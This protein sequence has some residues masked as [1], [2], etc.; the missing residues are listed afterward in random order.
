M[1]PSRRKHLLYCLGILGV[2]ESLIFAYSVFYRGEGGINGIGL[3]LGFVTL[4]WF[5]VM[6]TL[7]VTRKLR[8]KIAGG[9]TFLIL[10]CAEIIISLPAIIGAMSFGYVYELWF[11]VSLGVFFFLTSTTLT[12]GILILIT[13]FKND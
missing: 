7:H 11:T 12:G 8:Y 5:G 9:T 10:G 2:V 3:W 1:Y 6:A 13:A 4:T